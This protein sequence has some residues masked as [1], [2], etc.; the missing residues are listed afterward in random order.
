MKT[1]LPWLL[2]VVFGASAGALYFS[3]SSKNEELNTLRQQV[4]QLDG[5]RSQLADVQ[6]Q[7]ADQADQIASMQK[8]NQELLRLRGQV[9]QLGDEKAQLIKQIAAAQSQAERSQAEIQQVQ[10]RASENAKVMAEQQILQL[11]QNQGAANV[12][13][14]NLRMIDG[15]K[16]QWAL[17]HQKGPDAVPQPQE[18]A[19]YLP[20]AQIPQC[21]AGGRYTLNAVNRAPTCSIPG[22]V[23]Q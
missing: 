4:Q 5:L 8:D 16:Q 2:A 7:A 18:I 23:L 6:K 13:I 11:K 12:C 10:A 15:A 9:K 3:S 20:N 19:P 21:P 22:H 14:N 17:E 1:I